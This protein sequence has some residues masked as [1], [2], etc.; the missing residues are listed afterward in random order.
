MFNVKQKIYVTNDHEVDF[1]IDRAVLMH[2]DY[3]DVVFEFWADPDDITSKGL[4]GKGDTFEDILVNLFNNSIEGFFNWLNAEEDLFLVTD[5]VNY[6]KLYSIYLLELQETFGIT[7]AHLDVM[8]DCQRIKDYFRGNDLIDFASVFDATKA[9]HV[10]VGTLFTADDVSAL[11]F[12]VVFALYKWGYI[13]K[14]VATPKVA[15]ISERLLEGQVHSLLESVKV[16]LGNS[17]TILNEFVG[18]TSIVTI[19]DMIAAIEGDNLLR[20]AFRGDCLFNYADPA[21]RAEVMRL[22]EIAINNEM[23]FDARPDVDL[24]EI[25]M[26]ERLYVDQDIDIIDEARENFVKTG[27]IA[28]RN[29]KFNGLLMMKV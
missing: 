7:D 10:P 29:N 5:I 24:Q 27:F 12:E 17:P 9:S 8:I 28:S 16:I 6:T 18:G 21:E 19:E 3:T 14:A 23:D 20:T 22:C 4:V 13:T 1:V 2:A 25:Q 15:I 11:P 26:F